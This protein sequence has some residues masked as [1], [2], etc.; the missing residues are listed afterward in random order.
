MKVLY[1]SRLFSGL[2]RSVSEKSWKPTGV[3]TIYRII[4]A[5]SQET[6]LQLL[7]CAKDG[8]TSLSNL[9]DGRM[10]LSGL[11]CPVEVLA[12]TPNSSFLPRFLTVAC[13]ELRH[14]LRTLVRVVRERPDL[15]YIDHGN[16]W[17]AG[18]LARISSIPVVFRVM[19]VYPAMRNALEGRRLAHRYL[20]W[21]YRAP[22]ATVVC[23]QDGSG[24]E[25]WLAKAIAPNVSVHVLVNGVD[26]V[27]TTASSEPVSHSI[28]TDKI[29]VMFLGKL[30]DGKGALAFAE[31][32]V[33]AQRQDTNIHAVM[34][35]TGS[36]LPAIKTEFAN[37]GFSDRLTIIERL[38]HADVLGLLERSDI[39][40][41]LNRF[42]NLSNANLEAM[43]VGTAMIF[44]E[45]QPHSGVDLATDRIV[46]GDAIKRIRD[47]D[48]KAGLVRA[49]L[50][51]AASK[52][53]RTAM[54][55][56]VRAIAAEHFGD[57]D[58]RVE[59]EMSILRRVVD[60]GVLSEPRNVVTPREEA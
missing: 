50:Q 2:E 29:V 44:P 60:R 15:V 25:P 20:R 8:H 59:R 36:Q 45:A 21:C 16:V 28:P 46:S 56:K 55:D 1:V 26:D 57:W 3:P 49:V 19:G 22:F 39:Y 47:S 6:E 12:A 33:E 11:N 37:A 13:R 48:D 14:A 24:V 30:E 5:L 58:A 40:V 34:I 17:T 10:Q 7:L 35:G 42:G 9:K 43:R 27:P 23:T 52:K 18:I 4:E 38:P 41:S 32:I 53:M 51:L 54:S 31:G